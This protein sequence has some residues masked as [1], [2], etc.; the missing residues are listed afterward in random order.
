VV[1]PICI[2]F[3]KFRKLCVFLVVSIC[4]LCYMYKYI[5]ILIMVMPVS[6]KKYQ[7]MPCFVSNLHIRKQNNLHKTFS[8]LYDVNL[9]F[10]CVVSKICVLTVRSCHLINS[11]D[12]TKKV[13]IK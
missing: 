6:K 11:V 3:D 5:M 4:G 2:L 1:Y 9:W 8:N 13:N 10:N 7:H 12:L